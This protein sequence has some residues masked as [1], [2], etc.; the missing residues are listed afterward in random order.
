M[1]ASFRWHEGTSIVNVFAKRTTRK[2]SGAALIPFLL[3]FVTAAS[4]A[5]LKGLNETATQEHRDAQT[6]KALAEA[7]AA[8]IGYAIGGLLNSACID[9][10]DIN[11]VRPGDLPC[12]DRNNDGLAELACGPYPP[13]ATDSWTRLGRLPW[14][15]LGLQDLRDGAG[16]RLWYAVSVNFKNNTRYSCNPSNPDPDSSGC[17]N[18]DARGR[19]TVRT[20][21]GTVFLHDGSNPD[22]WTPSGAIAVVISPGKVLRRLGASIDQNRS[23]AGGSCDANDVCTTPNPTSTPK[24]R[25]R[26]YLD[27]TSV[28]DNRIFYDGPNKAS[29]T[30]GFIQGD[31]LDASQNTIVNDK[32]LSIG[33]DDIMPLLE[34]RVARELLMCF[35]EYAGNNNQRYPW[36]ARVDDGTGA[37]NY[38]DFL[39][40][41]FGRVPDPPFN[42]TTF[43]EPGMTNSWFADC[44]ISAATNWW[45]NW[46]EQVFYAVADAYKPGPAVPLPSCGSCLTVDP[47][48]INPDRRMAVMVAGTYLAA[49]PNQVR[50]N[51]LDKV[52]INNY[53]EVENADLDDIFTS[54]AQFR[55]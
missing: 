20:A 33:Y 32:L 37:P 55:V 9:Q 5:L 19:I 4:F 25:P 44:N 54:G 27:R 53:L 10:T 48:S 13:V 26:E 21:G 41:R 34:Q 17:L 50:A 39:N 16:E 15:T 3:V 14:K 46:K 43:S 28:E 18:S 8:L 23:C 1:D 40:T 31:I 52:N 11:C 45:L 35:E 2:Q 6:A 12:P 24:C 51:P 47:P 36:A 22:E 38:A 42:A 29:R 30:N 49:S 7:K